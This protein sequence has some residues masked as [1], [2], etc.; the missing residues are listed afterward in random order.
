C[1]NAGAGLCVE[2]NEPLVVAGLYRGGEQLEDVSLGGLTAA[3]CFEA[4]PYLGSG[5]VIVGDDG[6]Q[7][8]LGRL[9]HEQAS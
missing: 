6:T 8:R 3:L 5:E 2:D 7:V 4:G 1:P 9:P